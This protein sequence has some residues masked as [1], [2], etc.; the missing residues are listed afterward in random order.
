M[1]EIASSPD[2]SSKIASSS[3]VRVGRYLLKRLMVVGM[4]LIVGVYLSIIVANLG[5]Y[6][7]DIMRDR[8]DTSLMAMLLGGWLDDVD[9]EA[10]RN[11]IIEQTRQQMEAAAG[12]NNPFL[13]RCVR[14]LGQSLTFQVFDS[15]IKEVYPNTLF[16]FGTASLLLFFACLGLALV[17]SRQYGSFLDRLVVSLS[18]I[19]S[20]PSWVHGVLLVMLFSIQLG[21]LP[22]NV[23][24]SPVARIIEGFREGINPGHLLLIFQ[25]SLLPVMAIFLSIFFQLTYTW[26]TFF[27]IYSGE[28]YVEVAKAKGL[29]NR[30]VERQYILRPTLPYILTSFTLILLSFWQTSMALEVFFYWPGLGQLYLRNLRVFAYNPTIVM[31]IVTLFAYILA[32]TV[33]VLDIVYVLVDPRVRITS[34]D[35]GRQKQKLKGRLLDFIRWFQRSEQTWRQRPGRKSA[36]PLPATRPAAPDLKIASSSGIWSSQIQPTLREIIRYPSALIGLMAIFVMIAISVY[37]IVA[38]PYQ[39]IHTLWVGDTWS[40]YPEHAQPSWTNLFRAKKLPDTLQLNSQD[41]SAR[42]TVE[43]LNE[44]SAEILLTYGIDFQYDDFP[45]DIIVFFDADYNQKHPYVSLAWRTPDGREINL[46]TVTITS[47]TKIY[48]SQEDKIKR[49]AGG[50]HSPERSL[51]ADPAQP[52]LVPLKGYYELVITG[53]TFEKDSDLDAEVIVMGKVFGWAGTDFRR[54]DLSIALLWGTPIALALGFF[55]ALCTTFVSIGI[56]AVGAWFGGWVDNLVQAATEINIMLPIFP[57]SVMVYYMYGKNVWLTI[58]AII[59]FSILG[60]STKN[61][62]AAFLQIKD[63]Q[64]VEAARTYGASDWRVI[65]RYLAPRIVPVM[66]PQLVAMVPGYVFLEATLSIMGVSDPYIPTWGNIIYDALVNGAF[67]G[68]YY[69]ILEPI[70]LLMFTGLAFA[71]VGF[72][73]DRVFNPRL[74]SL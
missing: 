38:L 68:Y 66:V 30:Q 50:E 40:K 56:A 29:P 12:L 17:L 61:Y 16:L 53:I 44:N 45:Q 33:L 52:D 48:F 19:S 8:I 73:M 41:G 36:V 69:W 70:F 46:G 71:L 9:D 1:S 59:L 21:W 63:A 57:V 3:F 64:Y 6:I 31:G 37:T 7:D 28:D 72:A 58:G 11:A 27:L 22:Y 65:F 74:R 35:R 47:S 55:G 13:I 23:N 62:R 2:S 42:K 25:Y 15:Q 60:N 34:Q 10:Q 43:I 4:T 32:L 20:M 26:R 24:I 67:R 54:R 18:P 51:F 39:E 49:R 14:W 5:G